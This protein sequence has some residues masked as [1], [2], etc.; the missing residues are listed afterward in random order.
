MKKILFI[1][2]SAEPGKDGVGDYT[3]RLAVALV[4]KGYHVTIIAL[5]DKFVSE[6]V[7]EVQHVEDS[8]VSIIRIPTNIGTSIKK[9]CII[10]HVEENKP[11]WISLQYVPQAFEKRGLAFTLIS[12]LKSIPIGPSWHF[13]IHEIA[14]PK[15]GVIQRIIRIIQQKLLQQLYRLLKPKLVHTSITRYQIALQNLGISSTILP[16]FSNIPCINSTKIWANKQVFTIGFFSQLN[17]SS[18]IIASLKALAIRASTEGLK[19][20]I[21]LIGGKKE[22]N[23]EFI[24]F[25]REHKQINA[26]CQA[27]GY[28][29][30]TELSEQLT[31]CQLGISPIK[32]SALG[33][34]GSFAAF[35][36]HGVPVLAPVDTTRAASN[37]AIANYKVYTQ[38]HQLPPLRT[39]KANKSI[40]LLDIVLKTFLT[41]IETNN[42][43]YHAN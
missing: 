7:T 23:T 37:W 42:A 39:L 1:C 28:L 3:R 21:V 11:D 31:H 24:K 9:N 5:A 19:L 41:D 16:L 13:M 20:H 15:R 32:F 26:T 40:P 38:T 8:A 12:I 34:S 27:T 25:I 29:S 10:S 2:G 35:V 17:V 22:R 30:P 36:E 4:G 18:Y 14:V 33:K 43:E 6:L